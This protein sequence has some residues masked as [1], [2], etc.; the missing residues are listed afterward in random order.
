MMRKRIPDNSNY[1]YT[2]GWR[3]VSSSPTCF[4]QCSIDN[5]EIPRDND[6]KSIETKRILTCCR[7]AQSEY[8]CNNEM[9]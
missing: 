7:G 8:V 6:E 2:Q 9:Y 3:A 4:R 5:L 1:S